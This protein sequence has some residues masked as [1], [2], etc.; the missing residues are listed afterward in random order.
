MLFPIG[1][2][3]Y[4]ALLVS[5]RQ[6]VKSPMRGIRHLNL[7]VSYALSRFNSVAEDQDFISNAVDFRDPLHYM[8]P[9][10]LDR[11]D[12]ISVGAVADLPAGLRLGLIS[13]YDTALPGTLGLPTTGLPGEIFRT[14]IT[15]D[16]T[17]GDIL[18]GTNTGSFG[19]S[20]KVGD[21]NNV[22][23]AYN[24]KYA[25]TLTPA[26]QALVQAGLFTSAQLISLGAVTP[27]IQPAPPG[28][29]GIDALKTVDASLSWVLHPDKIL[30]RLPESFTIEPGV[31][32]FNVFN[33]ANFDPPTQLLRG[34]LNGSVG[35]AN[36][37]PP[38]LRTNRI[39]LGTGVFALGAPRIFEWG[40]KINF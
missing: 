39:G 27:T 34:T 1:R 9:N 17:T 16:G 4:N 38:A 3:V 6:D 35:S 29:V 33:F 11:T 19:R 2:S 20:V 31:S 10:S 26:G 13:H 40:L 7:Q 21:L 36:G 28:Q 8:G 37:T 30:G 32:A 12:Q 14:D 18:P 23:N 22:I 24:T 5:L 25:G 15:G